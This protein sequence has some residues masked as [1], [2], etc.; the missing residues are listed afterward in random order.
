MRNVQTAE[1]MSKLIAEKGEIKQIFDN[2]QH[3]WS[4]PQTADYPKKYIV[5]HYLRYYTARFK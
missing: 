5:A 4:K 3:F 1:Y 2:I